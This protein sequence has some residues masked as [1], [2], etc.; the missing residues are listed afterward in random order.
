MTKE[1]VRKIIKENRFIKD[2]IKAVKGAEWFGTGYD[3]YR[4]GDIVKKYGKTYMQ[5]SA[6]KGDFHYAYFVEVKE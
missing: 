2:R 5:I 3:N 1:E 4:V 6:N